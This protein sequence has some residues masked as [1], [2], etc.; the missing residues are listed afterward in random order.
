MG[1]LSITQG[2]LLDFCLLVSSKLLFIIETLVD[3]LINFS[4]SC[5]RMLILLGLQ[6]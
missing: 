5:F 2:L 6:C 1:S 4:F 3:V